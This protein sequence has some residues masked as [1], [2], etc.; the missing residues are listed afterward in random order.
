MRFISAIYGACALFAVRLI[1]AFCFVFDSWQICLCCP[2]LPSF[3]RMTSKSQL[4]YCV[5][6]FGIT[7]RHVYLA[8]HISS[9]H[10][11]SVAMRGW[12]LVP[13]SHYGLRSVPYTFQCQNTL[14]LDT[15]SGRHA[16]WTGSLSVVLLQW[17]IISWLVQH[18]W[19]PCKAK[20]VCVRKCTNSYYKRI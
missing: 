9:R 6:D 11:A 2:I 17:I 13:L 5:H 3:W 16:G 15:V 20:Q 7:E 18:V 1:G 4:Q 14:H 10:A 8:T 19:F 12:R